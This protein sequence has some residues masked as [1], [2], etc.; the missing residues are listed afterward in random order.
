MYLARKMIQNG[1]T[2]PEKVIHGISLDIESMVTPS[3]T[4]V[5]R[6]QA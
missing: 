2:P 5:Y 4:A 1:N 3:L 6:E